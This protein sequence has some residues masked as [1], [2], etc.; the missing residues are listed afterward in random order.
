VAEWLYRASYFVFERA[1]RIAALSDALLVVA[2][3]DYI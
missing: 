1:V 3:H 2:C